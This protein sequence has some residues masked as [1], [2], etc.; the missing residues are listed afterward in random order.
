M[1][2]DKLFLLFWD[3]SFWQEGTHE[4]GLSFFDEEKGYSPEEIED[5][6]RLEVGEVWESPDYG[7]SHTVERLR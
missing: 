1:D 3:S 6:G 5:I 4:T 2:K 7:T